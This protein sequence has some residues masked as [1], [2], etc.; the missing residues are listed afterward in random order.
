MRARLS[1]RLRRFRNDAPGHAPGD[2]QARVLAVAARKGGVGKTTTAVN[3]ACALA[4][5][6]GQQVLLIDLDPQGHVGA[7]LRAAMLPATVRISE[8]L[9]AER[10]RDLLDAVIATR[11]DG[12]HVTASDKSLGEAEAQLVSRIGRETVL[13][14]ALSTALTRYDT[15]I[16]DC[17]PM[18][19]TLTH[20]A[21]LAAHAVLIPCD[22]SILALEGVADLL[23]AV[24]VVQSRLRHPIEIEGI[25]RTRYDAR[26]KRVNAVVGQTL[27]DNFGDWLLKTRV[28]IN[29]A[30]AKA[31]TAGESIFSAD[32]RSRGAQAY[33]DLAAELIERWRVAAAAQAR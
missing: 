11:I 22:M 27:S 15:I 12:L 9:L 1:D 6:H 8:I 3:L 17:P 7:A 32:P 31:Q 13:Q 29:S 16:I 24:E 33:L 30:L 21:L 4:H 20:N 18:L 5:A 19:G 10:P 25:L 14:G 23:D 2:K 28:P 26:N